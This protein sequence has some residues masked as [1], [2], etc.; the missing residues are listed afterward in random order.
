[1]ASLRHIY[2]SSV[3]QWRMSVVARDCGLRQLVAF[4]CL[5]FRPLLDSA[6]SRTA[7][8]QCGTV[9]PQPCAKTCH[10]L[11]LRQNWKRPFS[12]VHDDSWRPPGVVAA[13]SRFRRRDISDFTYLL[14]YDDEV[15][16]CCCWCLLFLSCGK[17][18]PWT[19]FTSTLT[20]QRPT[21]C[22][23]LN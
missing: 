14:T 5:G 15:W 20:R 3:S 2:E 16:Y 7:V 9:C 22:E 17:R 21:L 19:D 4:Y 23:W 13:V 11:H 10:W 6:A 18:K 8:L 12:A 1:M